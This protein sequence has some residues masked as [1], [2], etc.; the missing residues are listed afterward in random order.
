[1]APALRALR[2]W[3]ELPRSELA[4]VATFI[5]GP[6]PPCASANSGAVSSIQE[7]V[8]YY[9]RTTQI[10]H[11]TWNHGLGPCQG[12]ALAATTR[13]PWESYVKRVEH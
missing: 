5:V 9:V 8:K 13:S 6:R 10:R 12:L 2:A 1:L 11:E 7:A 4:A 3:T